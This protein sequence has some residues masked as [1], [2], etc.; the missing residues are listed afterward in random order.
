MAAER[1]DQIDR[2][3]R[4]ALERPASERRAFVAASSYG[5]EE[6]RVA[7]EALLSKLD[8]TGVLR[9]TSGVAIGTMIGQYRVEGILA[10]GGMGIV[11]RATDTRLNRPAAIKFLS[12]D[13]LD[14]NARRRFQHEAQMASALNH[15]HILTV[16]DAGE[17]DGRQYL[18]TE[19]VDGGTL[20]DR[21]ENGDHHDW[22]HR[23]E[24]LIGVA[25]GLAA[26]HTAN[27][28]HRDIKPANIL[29]SKSGYAKLADF[30]L[31]KLTDGVGSSKHGQPR[32]AAGTVI[33]TI[34]YMSPEQAAGRALDQRSDVFSFGVVL[35]ELLTGRRP[36]VG[37]TDLEL[38]QAV[39]HGEAAPIGDDLPAALRTIVEK[40]IEK[41]PAERYQTMRD[42]VVDLRRVVRA[43]AE[44]RDSSLGDS[45]LRTRPGTVCAQTFSAV[46]AGR[47]AERRGLSRSRGGRL[48]LGACAARVARA[49]RDDSRDRA[50]R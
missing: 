17:L 7:V 15:P 43:G 24:L 46:M 40:A 38:L 1:Q 50:A 8:E 39:K 25:D 30:G 41:D 23:V 22:R 20:A 47:D 18:V 34:A 44:H 42:F 29:I 45:A 10:G 13:L 2:L 35:Y 28:L 19:F 48:G 14:A 5:D 49:R 33:G 27:I 3:Y 9:G 31:A 21:I 11:C 26:A 36:F 16:Y 37:A 12:D 4:A 6:L 32:T